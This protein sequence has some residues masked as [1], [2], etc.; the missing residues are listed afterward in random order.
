MENIEF[1]CPV[2]GI[3]NTIE[4]RSFPDILWTYCSACGEPLV[5]KKLR[6][7]TLRIPTEVDWATIPKELKENLKN[8]ILNLVT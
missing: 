1:I 8:K 5:M 7:K 3:S 2:C 6:D 4:A